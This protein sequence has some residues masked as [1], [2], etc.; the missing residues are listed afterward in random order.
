MG[1]KIAAANIRLK[2]AYQPAAADDG[3]RILVDRLWPRGVRKTDAA[4]DQWAKDLAPS[5]ALRQWF[6]HDPARWPEF[7]QRY[8]A[9][10]Q[11]QPEPLAQLRA[12]AQRQPVTL[13]FS[14]HDEAYN[15]AVA[16]RDFLLGKK[17]APAA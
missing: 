4:I 10:L 11:Q 7:C 15:N 17:S 14:A 5:T 2:R 1:G 6:G 8:A 16:L 9:E 13:V 12:L 3:Q